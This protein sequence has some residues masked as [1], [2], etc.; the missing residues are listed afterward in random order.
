[1]ETSNIQTATP[2]FG[3]KYSNPKCWNPK[4]LQTLAESNLIKEIDAKY[5]KAKAVYESNA[6]FDLAYKKVFIRLKPYEEE[7]VILHDSSDLHT[8]DRDCCTIIR[9]MTLDLLENQILTKKLE[10]EETQIMKKEARM[11]KIKKV[12]ENLKNFFGKLFRL[13][14]SL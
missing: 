9:N 11:R 14:N 10:A 13:N 8:F 2:S 12:K 4:V 6:L 3:I 7:A 5:P 1:M